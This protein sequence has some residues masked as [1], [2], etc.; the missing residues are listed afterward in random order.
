MKL[1][2]MKFGNFK[3]IKNYYVKNQ[4]II[5]TGKGTIFYSYNTKIVAI[6]ENQ[7]YL[8]EKYWNYSRTTI[9]YRNMFLE[10]SG[11]EIERKIKKG[12]YLLANLNENIR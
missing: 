11:K 9:K 5:E 4:F 2:S 10:E 1:K 7:V 8:D 12:I 6:I 3:K